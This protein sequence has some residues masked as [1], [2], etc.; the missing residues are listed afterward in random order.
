MSP[1]AY[2]FRESIR[3]GP[4]SVVE[5][6]RVLSALANCVPPSHLNRHDGRLVEVLLLFRGGRKV[7]HI[8]GTSKQSRVRRTTGRKL[9]ET[10][11]KVILQ[12]L[13]FHPT[14][15][16]KMTVGQLTVTSPDGSQPFFMNLSLFRYLCVETFVNIHIN[17][18]NEL[19]RGPKPRVAKCTRD[20]LQ[21]AFLDFSKTYAHME[22]G[23]MESTEIADCISEIRA[24]LRDAGL[25]S[26]INGSMSS[27][28]WFNT[29][30]RNVTLIPAPR[31]AF[32]TGAE[33][34]RKETRETP[35]IS[36]CASTQEGLN[37][38]CR[39]EHERF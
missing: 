27:G 15:D 33:Q 3:F 4:L 21:D 35:E 37:S 6:D 36:G 32:I 18:P 2:R 28:F 34:L 7:V 1:K 9:F 30:P 24:A 38:K 17:T 26:L 25:A 39:S 31:F 10:D 20:D 22:S 14:W 23:E 29:H 5:G 11:L 12:G 8:D 13:H 19:L 16:K